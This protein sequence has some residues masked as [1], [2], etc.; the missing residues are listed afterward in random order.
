MAFT[1]F[2]PIQRVFIFA[3]K[4]VPKTHAPWW[5]ETF[6]YARCWCCWLE[7]TKLNNNSAFQPK[8][9]THLSQVIKF[10]QSETGSNR[11]QQRFH[12]KVQQFRE[13]WDHS[14]DNYEVLTT[15]HFKIY[16]L[17]YWKSFQNQPHL[18]LWQ[19]SQHS[20]AIPLKQPRLKIC[21]SFMWKGIHCIF[22]G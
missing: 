1:S 15:S 14:T 8:H 12:L 13:A 3:K 19:L 9:E 16:L 7:K 21:K 6:F 18:K 5:A 11:F 17:V 20:R 2:Q 4:R 22:I 10:H